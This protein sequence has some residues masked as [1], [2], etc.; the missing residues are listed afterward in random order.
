MIRLKGYCVKNIF[1]S[2]IICLF[3]IIYNQTIIET[4][5]SERASATRNTSWISIKSTDGNSVKM[6]FSFR[7]LGVEKRS[8][9]P[10]SSA[11]W[12]GASR[13]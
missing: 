6:V 2:E 1:L 7:V 4:N 10:Y 3:K 12:R 9:V 11:Y 5:Y 8:I 13:L